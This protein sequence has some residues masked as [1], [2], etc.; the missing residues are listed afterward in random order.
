LDRRQANLESFWTF[1]TDACAMP[2]HEKPHREMVEF[3]AGDSIA[4]M[5]LVPRECWK[6]SIGAVA[7]PLWRV[8]R[9]WFLEGIPHFRVI[10]DSATLDLSAR[11]VGS[12]AGLLQT[13][14]FISA[15]GDLYEER[16][17]HPT[18]T[19]LE[20]SFRYKKCPMIRE[21][22]FLASGIRAEKTGKHCEI[23]VFDDLVTKINYRTPEQRLKGYEHY[24][25]M[26]SVLT[27]GADGTRSE[28]IV[29][30]T[31]Y[32][33]A[34]A[35][36][37]IIKADAERLANGQPE[38]F[39]KM[40]RTAGHLDGGDL[41]F[42]GEPGKP[43][44]LPAKVLEE[45][46]RTQGEMFWAQ[47]FNDPNK[48][49]APFKRKD[50][51]WTPLEKFPALYKVRLTIDP[52][53]KQDE[54]ARG[55]Y[56]AMTAAGWNQWHQPYVLGVLLRNDLGPGS[57]ILQMLAMSRR[58]SCSEI[59]IEDD[60][61]LAG[62]EVLWRKEMQ[63]T[64]YRVPIRLV[65]VNPHQGKETRWL[66]LQEYTAHGGVHLAE[67]I[68]EDTRVEL[69]DQW[70]RAPNATHDDWMDSFYLQTIDLPPGFT[71]GSAVEVRDL[72]R[73]GEQP[74]EIGELVGPM[75]VK[76]R[77]LYRGTLASRFP[78]IVSLRG[79]DAEAEPE[80]DPADDME[81]LVQ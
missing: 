5:M 42:P 53:I 78:H 3:Y 73:D 8:L 56:T 43:G 51:H 60:G 65:K 4:K 1:A 46:R 49:S 52:A 81:A 66:E 70:C 24:L 33:D 9:A 63:R 10:I 6:T 79:S 76:D 15:F 58:F 59:L 31:R 29:N 12:I 80:Y 67:E 77:H 71:E 68:P 45:L 26:Q 38:K 57:F 11:C 50:L 20:L 19:G 7:Y 14:R 2:L 34:D 40:I 16:A 55:D 37:R 74:R 44:G 17:D 13:P 39:T 62:M 61:S 47:Y 32:H 28:Q 64:G 35:Y 41:F 21:P 75:A 22:N 27:T 30:G 54:V 48:E 23:A 25:S 69:E 18:T 36:G 72:E